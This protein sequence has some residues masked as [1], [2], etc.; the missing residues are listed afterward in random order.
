MTYSGSP[1]EYWQ[2]NTRKYPQEKACPKVAGIS[3]LEFFFNSEYSF[4]SEIIREGMIH[5]YC[6]EAKNIFVSFNP[7][8]C[9]QPPKGWDLIKF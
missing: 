5:N 2:V 3:H 6:G 8:T 7:C 9:F 1:S 4:S